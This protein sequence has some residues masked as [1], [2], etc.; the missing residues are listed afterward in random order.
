MLLVTS[1]A[2]ATNWQYIGKN[3]GKH[4]LKFYIDLNSINSKVIGPDVIKSINMEITEAKPPYAPLGEYGQFVWIL[5]VD[6]T[7][8][9][10]NY[11][12][13]NSAN[14]PGG[15]QGG[16]ISIKSKIGMYFYRTL[17]K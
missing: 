8:P 9:S 5:N 2:L 15:V 14:Y 1:T 10:V 13:P 6:C 11:I 12:L 17:C 3:P 16:E 4:G 7:E